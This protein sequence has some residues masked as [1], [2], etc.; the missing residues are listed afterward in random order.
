MAHV[1]TLVAHGAL[2]EAW[3]SDDL[4]LLGRTGAH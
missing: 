4:R 2:R 3:S 1:D